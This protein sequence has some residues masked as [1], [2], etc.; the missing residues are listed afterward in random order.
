MNETDPVSP[1]RADDDPQAHT[2]DAAAPRRPAASPAS[3]TSPVEIAGP[4]DAEPK[5][6][7]EAPRPRRRTTAWLVGG[8]AALV[9]IGLIVWSVLQQPAA[10][11][12]APS[13]SD[14][15]TPSPS[16]SVSQ[17]PALTDAQLIA[18]TELAK[19]R[20]KT[21]W[22]VQ[23]PAATG[24]PTQPA[25]V[26]LSAT[27]GASPDA[28]LNR[29][30]TAAKG[31]GTILQVVQA[32]PDA[33]SATTAFNALL[34]QAGSCT[35]GLLRSADRVTGLADAATVLTVQTGDGATHTL[36]FV[37]SGRFVSLVDGGVPAGADALA[38]NA[39]VT[40]SRASQGRQCGPASGTCPTNPN[41]VG[42]APPPTE[43]IGWLAWVDLPRVTSGAGTWTATEPLAPK[44]IGSQ[45]ENVNL[46]KLSGATESLHRTYLLTNDPKAPE[47]FG[48]DEAVYSYA[49]ASGASDMAKQLAKNFDGCGERTRTATVKD[50]SVTAPAT[51]G[52]DLKA[53]SYLVTQRV[54][55]ARTV[56]FRVGIAAI[57][58]KLVYLLANPSDKFDFSDDAW[59]AIVGRATQRVTQS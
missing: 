9:V 12:A 29:L 14:S 43:T 16:A 49:K 32:W 3:P 17:P 25:C 7:A 58:D 36:L 42:T 53:T 44:L 4:A 26:E 23:A 20:T 5:G 55:E 31:D 13:V 33:T 8:V 38:V 56:T 52:K 10:P 35:D 22:T 21:S 24:V 54:S 18:T 1:R 19:V 6:A 45:C 39:V 30:F 2:G 37:R 48:I 51:N 15:G 11:T 27:G 40:A 59:K 41:T 57:G 50:A 47:G 28:E 34:T 46:N